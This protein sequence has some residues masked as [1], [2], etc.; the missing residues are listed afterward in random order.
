MVGDKV[1]EW[2]AKI[3]TSSMDRGRWLN[4]PRSCSWLCRG[5]MHSHMS[6]DM[7]GSGVIQALALS[8]VVVSQ[9]RWETRMLTRDI[10]VAVLVPVAKDRYLKFRSK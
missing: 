2:Q 5:W 6:L 9:Q 8:P 10:E 4:R 1:K 3:N 7:H